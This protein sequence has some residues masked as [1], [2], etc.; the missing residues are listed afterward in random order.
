MSVRPDVM[1]ILEVLDLGARL[2]HEVDRDLRCAVHELG[3]ELDR[4]LVVAR[5]DRVRATPDA[6]ARLEDLDLHTVLDQ[7]ARSRQSRQARTDHR[8]IRPPHAANK[9]KARTGRT[10]GRS[11]RFPAHW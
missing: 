6:L 4:Q 8:N 5:L 9:C 3:T 10:Y 2:A 11:A 1:A 7:R